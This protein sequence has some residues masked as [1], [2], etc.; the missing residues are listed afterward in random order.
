MLNTEFKTND[1]VMYGGS[2]V[3]IIEGIGVP[4][5]RGIDSTKQYYL[6]KP[7]YTQDSTIFSP[8]DNSRVVMRRLISKEEAQELIAQIPD[9]DTIWDDNEKVREEKYL[10]ALHSYSCYEWMRMIKTLYLKIE[11][12]AQHKKSSGEKDQR[13]LRMAE[14]LLYGE[15]AIPL[16]IKK[17]QVGPYIAEQMRLAEAEVKN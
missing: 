14:D 13:Y 7:I 15:L 11:D 3:C 17:D 2:G 1:Y 6:L 9:I 4:D 5:I 8:V 12:R 16:A 10:E